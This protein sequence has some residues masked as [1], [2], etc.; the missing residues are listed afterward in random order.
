MRGSL[1]IRAAVA[2]AVALLAG[3]SGVRADEREERDRKARAALALTAPS[4]PKVSAA[5]QPREVGAEY[6]TA[7]A[8]AV[9]QAKPLVVYVGCKSDHKAPGAVP[10]KADALP[11]VKAPAAVV[12]YPRGDGMLVHRVMQCPV[13]D[14]E[15]QAAIKDAAKKSGVGATGKNADKPAPKPLDWQIRADFD[16]TDARTELD[17][18]RDASVRVWRDDGFGGSGTVVYAGPGRS[19]IVTAAHVVKDSA[20]VEVRAGG[21]PLTGKVVLLD[22]E[23]DWAAVE[24]AKELPCVVAVG[25]DV[26]EGDEALLIGG[27]S[28]WTRGKVVE[29]IKLGRPGSAREVETW[30]LDYAS[31]SG[32]SGGGVFVRGQLV[33]VH[34]G[35]YGKAGEYA[36]APRHFAGFCAKAIHPNANSRPAYL[37][38][39]A[40]KVNNAPAT[41]AA[42]DCPN[43]KCALKPSPFAA[44][45][46]I[47]GGCANGQCEV[48][49][50]SRG[51][52]FRRR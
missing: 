33:A 31:T 35:R 3:G 51:G 30:L 20:R 12:M 40:P 11:G 39:P 44:P 22:R 36:R 7:Y 10:A 17:V 28:V 5:P 13:D 2:C 38:E 49:N 9:E 6:A 45:V 46:V 43:G 1:V 27:S 52:F 25:D 32:D 4:A 14:A 26:K 23:A 16:R 42:P 19:V 48:P 21:N 34:V 29:S 37:P 24:V 41:S 47:Q 15:L 8:R 18:L 50:Y